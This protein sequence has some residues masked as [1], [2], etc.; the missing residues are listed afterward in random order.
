[1]DGRNGSKATL[2]N[3]FKCAY[4]SEKVTY[5]LEDQVNWTASVDVYKVYTGVHVDKL[6]TSGHAVCV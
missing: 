6:G 4:S 2:C 5:F 1:M 3:S